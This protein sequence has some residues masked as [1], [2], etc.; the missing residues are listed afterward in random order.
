[1]D[2]QMENQ[3]PFEGVTGLYTASQDSSTMMETHGK[4]DGKWN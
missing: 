3:G 2:N 4:S 1:M